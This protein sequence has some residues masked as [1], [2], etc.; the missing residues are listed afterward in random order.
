MDSLNLKTSVEKIL[1]MLDDNK[2]SYEPEQ[3]PGLMYKDFGASFLL[4]PS[5]KV[6]ATGIRD[7]NNGEEALTKFRLLIEQIR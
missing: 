6:I 5:G 1:F 7:L 3:F 4:F 2:A